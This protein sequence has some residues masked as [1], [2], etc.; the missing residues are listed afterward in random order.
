[1]G[2]VLAGFEVPPDIGIDDIARSHGE[3]S[4]EEDGEEGVFRGEGGGHGC[5]EKAASFGAD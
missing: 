2:N 1:M 3:E 4:K 5:G